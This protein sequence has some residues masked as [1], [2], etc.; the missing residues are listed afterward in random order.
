MDIEELK[1]KWQALDDRV[2]SLERVNA[3]LS[4]EVKKE[5]TGRLIRRDDWQMLPSILLD[6]L[7]VLLLGSFIADHHREA[8]FLVPALMLQLF[9][10][11]LVIVRVRHRVLLHRIDYD[12]PVLANQRRLE[13]VRVGRFRMMK[14]IFVVAPLLWTPLLIVS[15]KALFGVDAYRVLGLPY[16]LANV[17]FGVAAIPVLSALA[18]WG[19]R[20]LEG[21]PALKRICDDLAG[22]SLSDAIRYLDSLVEFEQEA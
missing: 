22:R 3:R 4:G 10:L 2:Q 13:H 18:G 21:R 12:A 1:T 14:L 16:L 5:R 6:A 19:A 15:L 20:K 8:R 11:G 17:A 7:A 9:V